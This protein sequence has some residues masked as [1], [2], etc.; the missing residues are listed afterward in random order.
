MSDHLILEVVVIAMRDRLRLAKCC[1]V[2]ILSRM[3][4]H[5]G[6]T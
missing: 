3:E 6:R 5:Y 4:D 1:R 2:P